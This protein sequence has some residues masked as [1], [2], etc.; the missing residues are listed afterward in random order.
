MADIYINPSAG[1][2][3][4][5]GTYRGTYVNSQTWAVGDRVFDDT[6]TNRIMFECTTAGL[7]GASTPVFN[8]TIGG[9]TNDNAAVWTAREPFTWANATTSLTRGIVNL[10]AG[11]RV[12]FGADNGYSTTDA[13]YALPGTFTTP[14]YVYSVSESAAEEP[15]TET[16]AGSALWVTGSPALIF[17]G[18]AVFESVSLFVGSGTTGTYSLRLCT[19]GG[20]QLWRSPAFSML[21]SNAGGRIEIGAANLGE[22]C[23]VTLEDPYIQF[24]NAAHGIEVYGELFIKGGY[25]SGLSGA[26]F[27][28]VIG[29]SNQVARIVVEGLEFGYPSNLSLCAG[30]SATTLRAEVVFRDCIMPRYWT[31]NLIKLGDGV[32]VGFRVSLYNCKTDVDGTPFRVRIRDY[33]GALQD[34]DLVYNEGSDFC[35][36][37]G[38]G[39]GGVDWSPDRGFYTD[40]FVVW[41]DEVGNPIDVTIEF[42]TVFPAY[43]EPG[44]FSHAW[45]EVTYPSSA[46]DGRRTMVTSLPDDPV[47]HPSSSYV[48]STSA[49][50]AV[51]TRGDSVGVSTQA[52]RYIQGR[53]WFCTVGGVTASSEPAG[54]ATANDGDSVVDGTA[55][56]TAMTRYKITKTITPAARGVVSVRFAVNTDTLIWADNKISVS[57]KN[58]ASGSRQYQIPGG[59]CVDERV[60]RTAY[61][62][63]EGIN[64]GY[65]LQEGAFPVDQTLRPTGIVSITK[66]SGSH[67]DIDDSNPLSPDG[68][69][70]VPSA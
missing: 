6:A 68:N 61:A 32:D 46:T 5:S 37:I 50:E 20:V 35:F 39:G 60:T 27:I 31:G 12:F 22:M 66:L 48:A 54:Y 52:I 16:L 10:L 15:P 63:M 55:T 3:I 25:V 36:Y 28:T 43:F 56:F 57:V 69:W 70:L 67:T 14:N 9:T 7:G 51:Q 18:S 29:G 23:Q 4:G 30:M 49:W 17:S 41:I 53:V 19:T 26:T 58:E 1:G 8:Y 2:A 38:G 33:F 24:E 21:N 11:D 62:L 59:P 13:S 47:D 45:L 65:A 44:G 42:L 34:S 40:E 64:T